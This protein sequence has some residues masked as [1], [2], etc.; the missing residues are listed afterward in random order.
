AP[1]GGA[2]AERRVGQ[3]DVA[4]A[5]LAVAGKK[6]AALSVRRPE[7]LHTVHQR[8]GFFAPFHPS[9]HERE[10]ECAVEIEV[11]EHRA[12]AGAAPA[13][14]RQPTGS[15]PVLKK[16]AWLLLPKPVLF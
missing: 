7:G 15:H 6:L 13:L 11:R 3:R 12:E 4:K 16:S 14:P 2:A 1:H 8:R 10:V 9:V 5:T